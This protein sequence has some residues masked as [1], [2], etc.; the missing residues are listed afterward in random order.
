MIDSNSEIGTETL[1]AGAATIAEAE[2]I[3]LKFRALLQAGGPRVSLDLRALSQVDVSFFQLILALGLSL[4]A[5]GKSLHI[6]ALP[7]GHVVLETAALLGI[8]LGR[9]F[10]PMAENR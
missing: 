9:L 8:D 10:S 5:A 1:L 2:V 7:G 6:G 4:S 3:A